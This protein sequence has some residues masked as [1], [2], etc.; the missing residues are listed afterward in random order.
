MN[1]SAKTN[2]ALEIRELEH[3]YRGDDAFA[4]SIPRLDIAAGEAVALCGPSGCGKSTLLQLVAG[5]LDADRGSIRIGGE[6]LTKLRGAARD[7]FRGR[8]I[9]FIFQTL[10]LAPGFTARENV[11][12]AM[13]FADAG[14][15]ELGESP[16]ERAGSLLGAL[17]IDAPDRPVEEY[18][19][20]QQQRVAVARALACR[21]PLVLAD[22]PTA[23]LDPENA[24]RAVD[25]IRETCREAGAA[26]LL[27][28]HDPA[29]AER[30]GK[31]VRM[32]E[33]CGKAQVAR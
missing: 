13:R 1:A 15:N 31:T 2:A 14:R 28:T 20:G 10:N 22:E 21:P 17:A 5:L 11:M 24:R 27:V 7:R 32:A 8:R 16:A 26:L 33:I 6:D 25:L 18:S 23:S 12:L 3:S 30:V 19:L 9:G 29:I 4:L